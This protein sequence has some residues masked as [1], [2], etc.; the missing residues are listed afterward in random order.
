MC[1]P[2]CTAH[3]EVKLVGKYSNE[4]MVNGEVNLDGPAY[5]Q[6]WG[7]VDASVKGPW[8]FMANERQSPRDPYL[9]G[10]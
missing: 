6:Y 8:G 5:I 3:S 9:S 4:S 2:Q 7:M 10:I 1:L